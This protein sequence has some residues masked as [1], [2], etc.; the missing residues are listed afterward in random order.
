MVPTVDAGDPTDYTASVDWNTTG[1]P[2]DSELWVGVKAWDTCGNETDI[3]AYRLRITDIV[4]PTARII[5]FDPDLQSH[6]EEPPT[7]VKIYALAESDPDIDERH[8]PVRRG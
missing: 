6:G 4:P 5:A 8:L 1:I 7:C 3:V 2:V